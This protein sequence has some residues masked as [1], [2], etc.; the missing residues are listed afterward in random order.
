MG[1][2][3][4]KEVICKVIKLYNLCCTNK[5]RRNS[6]MSVCLNANYIHVNKEDT[7]YVAKKQKQKKYQKEFILASSLLQKYVHVFWV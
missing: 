2:G 4:W 1:G 5:L 3:R 7:D 6:K